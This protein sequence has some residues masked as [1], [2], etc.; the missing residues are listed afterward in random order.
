MRAKHYKDVAIQYAKDVVNGVRI[1]GADVANACRRF[2]S[3]LERPDLEFR[4]TE[5]DAAVSIIEG[6]FVHRKGIPSA[7]CSMSRDSR[8]IFIVGIAPSP[9]RV[10]CDSRSTGIFAFCASRLN[11]FVM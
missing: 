2:L 5:P 1:E 10:N 9:W 8:S 3:D 4:E 11:S 7:S 6:F